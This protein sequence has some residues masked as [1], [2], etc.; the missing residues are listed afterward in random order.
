MFSSF[1][2]AASL[3]IFAK[4]LLK[5]EKYLIYYIFQAFN[6]NTELQPGLD[7]FLV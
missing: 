1:G 4:I 2:F 6:V 5:R 7:D 3:A